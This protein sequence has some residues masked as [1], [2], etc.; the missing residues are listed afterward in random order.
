M[1]RCAVGV[2]GGGGRWESCGGDALLTRDCR[3]QI[4]SRSRDLSRI[5]MGKEHNLLYGRGDE[6]VERR[7]EEMVS[8]TACCIVLNC[9]MA[10]ARRRDREA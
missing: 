8:S 3:G 4:R 2:V 7:G 10:W 1:C 9:C 5:G 6:A